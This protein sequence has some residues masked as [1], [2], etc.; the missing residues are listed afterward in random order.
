MNPNGWYFG[1]PGIV[2]RYA[3]PNQ[4]LGDYDYDTLTTELEWLFSTAHRLNICASTIG[5]ERTKRGWHMT[6]IWN[7]RFKP[8]EIVMI[9]LLL[10]SDIQ[11]ERLNAQR[12]M[13]GKASNRRWN[14][15][16]KEKLV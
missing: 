1:K 11:R 10:G 16:F 14:L 6:V 4:T 2:K 13:S 8:S 7:R 12:I 15:L 5:L 3:S 9:Q